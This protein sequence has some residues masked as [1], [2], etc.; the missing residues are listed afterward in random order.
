MDEDNFFKGPQRGLDGFLIPDN[1]DDEKYTGSAMMSPPSFS[2]STPSAAP[3]TDFVTPVKPTRLLLSP[4]TSS[5]SK[6]STD[7]GRP[8]P[9]INSVG[10]SSSGNRVCKHNRQ[11]ASCMKCFDEFNNGKKT[12]VRFGNICEHRKFNNA[13]CIECGR[14]P[15]KSASTV[16]PVASSAVAS[17]AVDGRY[18]GPIMNQFGV[19]SPFA[20]GVDGDDEH[21][22]YPETE[23]YDEYE[24]M[25]IGG[26]KS[27]RKSAR[28]LIK[29]S[30][31]SS[32]KSKRSSKKAKRSSKKA[33]RS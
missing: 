23:M 6:K 4:S 33:K 9:S 12:P 26:R 17:S 13:G 15:K 31:R 2:S 19:V 25:N 5:R 18:A 16:L 22:L 3:A 1:D 32:R 21:L 30:K 11:P 10:I 27:Y 24:G 29:K 8:S 7:P 14:A 28:K 20:H